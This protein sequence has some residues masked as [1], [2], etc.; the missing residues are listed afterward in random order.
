MNDGLALRPA[1]GQ[2]A[3]AVGTVRG[4]ECQHAIG[5]GE[6]AGAGINGLLCVGEAAEPHVAKR[7]LQQ[8]VTIGQG[9]KLLLGVGAGQQGC[10]LVHDVEHRGQLAGR[11]QRSA[12][13][14][15]DDPIHAHGARDVD[16]HVLAQY[17]V[18]QQAAIHFDRGEESGQCQA[19]SDGQ[20]QVPVVE[21]HGFTCGN[22]GRHGTER[23]RQ[24]VEVVDFIGVDQ[25][26]FQ[27]HSHVL[28]LQQ[29]KRQAENAVV[30]GE[31]LLDQE[32]TVVLFAT[33]GY[34]FALGGVTQRI[35]PVQFE[36]E[37]LQ[38]FGTV[39]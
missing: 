29:A 17:T 14:N 22:V 8:Q 3:A 36:C 38:F 31:P 7:R 10:C 15:H 20:R 12:D 4:D 26:A 9:G 34:V 30:E 11:L 24:P 21:Y 19:G 32:V 33:V 27:H 37:L 13:V 39:A 16:G 18:H 6:A 1:A 23:D 5:L 25:Q 28:A 35:L 2:V